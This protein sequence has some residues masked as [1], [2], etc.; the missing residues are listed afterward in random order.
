L[1]LSIICTRFPGREREQTLHQILPRKK[2]EKSI[3]GQPID[4]LRTRPILSSGLSWGPKKRE[5]RPAKKTIDMSILGK[6][7]KRL[8]RKNR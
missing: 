7:G 4:Q 8:L 5:K 6:C 1:G 2:K 3:S